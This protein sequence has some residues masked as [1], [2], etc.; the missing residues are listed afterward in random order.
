MVIKHSYPRI[1]SLYARGQQAL[2]DYPTEILLRHIFSESFC[3]TLPRS[4]RIPSSGSKDTFEI[5]RIALRQDSDT[6]YGTLVVTADNVHLVCDMFCDIHYMLRREL[7]NHVN[8]PKTQGVSDDVVQEISSYLWTL[9]ELEQV[10]LLDFLF[11]D[12]ALENIFTGQYKCSKWPFSC[13][14]SH[15]R[16]YFIVAER[17]WNFPPEEQP[18]N[19]GV[20]QHGVKYSTFGYSRK[21]GE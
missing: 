13:L 1:S 5:R 16:R 15:E 7:L 14:M 4:F 18:D 12:E 20:Y 8:H 10:G 11:E 21:C 3:D 6:K 17:N 2:G 9:Y 19:D